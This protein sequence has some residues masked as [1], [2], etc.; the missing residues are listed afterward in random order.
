[1]T[2]ILMPYH[3]KS[4]V[5]LEDDVV[6][7]G[8]EMFARQIYTSIPGVIPVYFNDDDRKH[9]TATSKIVEA[10]RL[11]QPDVVITNY[12]YRTANLNLAK[13]VPDIPI[14]WVCHLG[15]GPMSKINE[16]MNM[17]TFMRDY[18]NSV[19]FV[20]ENQYLRMNDMSLRLNKIGLDPVSGY[21]NPAYAKGDEKVADNIEFDCVTIGRSDKVKDP[22]WLHRKLKKIDTLNC[23]VFTDSNPKEAEYN[24]KNLL[25][26]QAKPTFRG[27]PHHVL[28][29]KLLVSNSYV[30]PCTLE[31][32]GITALESLA[33]GVPLLL[34]RDFFGQHASECIPAREDHFTTFKKMIKASEFEEL[35]RGVRINT[36]QAKR[37]DISGL[38]KEKHSKSNWVKSI[39]QMIDYTIENKK[40]YKPPLSFFD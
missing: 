16:C 2:R 10:M 12:D 39:E 27:M 3:T 19:F 26:E 17:N 6:T 29:E 32:W 9:R 1:M 31:T 33:R 11:H 36:T 28:M 7:G 40:N 21:V 24:A 23:A 34:A 13:N 8:L 14:V 25:L 37:E 4:G 18:S 35:I 38:T 5:T 22:F 15:P 30:S 20:S